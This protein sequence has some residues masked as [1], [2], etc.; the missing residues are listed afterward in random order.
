M[1]HL[2]KKKQICPCQPKVLISNQLPSRTHNNYS[3]I[4]FM[5]LSVNPIV[6][7]GHT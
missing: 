6:L 1:N 5:R 4:G 7:Y 3:R 2:H